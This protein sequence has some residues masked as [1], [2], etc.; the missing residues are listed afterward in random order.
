MKSGV[1]A[2]LDKVSFPMKPEG[3]WGEE[4]DKVIAKSEAIKTMATPG[5]E[6]M[7]TIIYTSGTLVIFFFGN[8]RRLNF[9]VC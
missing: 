2:D 8:R 7:A 4:W 6:N 3:D 9:P 5:T 1:P